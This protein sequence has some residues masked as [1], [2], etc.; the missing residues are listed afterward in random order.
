MKLRLTVEQAYGL[1][2]GARRRRTLRCVLVSASGSRVESAYRPDH[3]PAMCSV[4]EEEAAMKLRLTV[5][6]A[7]GLL[8]GARWRWTQGACSSL[9]PALGWRVHA[10]ATTQLRC[11]LYLRRSSHEAP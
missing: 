9:P 3:T 4:C 6:Q 11:A 8:H 10:T 1:L 7:Y 2:H 5:E